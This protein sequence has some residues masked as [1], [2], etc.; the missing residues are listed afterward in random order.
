MNRNIL[1]WGFPPERGRGLSFRRHDSPRK[2]QIW[3]GSYH[4]RAT[5]LTARR[6]HDQHVRSRLRDRSHERRAPCPGVAIFLWPT[7]SRVHVCRIPPT[8]PL[9]LSLRSKNAWLAGIVGK[10]KCRE[11]VYPCVLPHSC[12]TVHDCLEHEGENVSTA[13]TRVA[14]TLERGRMWH[15]SPASVGV[16]H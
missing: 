3:F 10:L 5:R 7:R 9:N 4:V 15:D 8:F 6:Y 1:S 16:N 14:R 2:A 13:D 11:H 12:M